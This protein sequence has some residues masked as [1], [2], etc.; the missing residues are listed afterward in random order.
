[1][2]LMRM[3]TLMAALAAGV[4][5]LITFPTLAAD[6]FSTF[7]SALSLRYAFDLKNSVHT[8]ANEA[9]NTESNDDKRQS[10]INL[11]LVFDFMKW[12]VG[13]TRWTHSEPPAVRLVSNTQLKT[14]YFG[15]GFEPEAIQMHSLYSRETHIVY[16][17]DTWNPDNLFDRSLL[18]HELVHHLQML[19]KL[20]MACPEEYEAQAYQ[21]Q[22]E[23]L[24]EQGIQDPYK[25]LG[26]TELAIDSL[27]QCP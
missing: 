16:L 27:S 9:F 11:P 6:E 5:A 8:F 14:L 20:R 2:R 7:K 4:F 23:W 1:M 21:L 17:R 24:R 18:V 13:K 19:N 15:F 22:I 10:R 3:L 26:L 12:I 25:L